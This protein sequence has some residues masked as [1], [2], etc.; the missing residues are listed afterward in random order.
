[1]EGLLS[2]TLTYRV[3]AIVI[4][5]LHLQFRMKKIF[6]DQQALNQQTFESNREKIKGLGPA[7][8]S[9]IDML[10]S[11]EHVATMMSD[12]FNTPEIRGK[13]ATSD[14]KILNRTKDI[15]KT[16]RYVRNKLGGHV[17]LD[18][19]IRICETHNFIG[20]PLSED[21][22]TDISVYNFLLIESAMNITRS[23]SDIMGRDIDCRANGLPEETRVLVERLNKDWVEV[24]SY[25]SPMMHKLYEIAKPEKLA[26]TQP[27]DRL[28]LV[29]GD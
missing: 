5:M 12:I 23:S 18:T 21:L 4:K 6:D 22:E 13:L 8:Y 7:A 2:T 28:G 19:V 17:D 20:V 11:F 14:Y 15:A 24:F 3:S 29:V 1:M 10:I 27:E 16:W 26:A 9:F 25:F